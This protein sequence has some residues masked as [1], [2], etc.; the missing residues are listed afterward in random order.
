MGSGDLRKALLQL[1]YLLATGD[2]HVLPL[3]VD[4]NHRNGISLWQKI[5]Q[6]V[7][8]PAVKESKRRKKISQESHKDVDVLTEIAN[9]LENVSLISKL[10]ELEDISVH[11]RNMKSVMSLSITEDMRPYSHSNSISSNIAD[12]LTREIIHKKD[13][14][15][16]NTNKIFTS[17]LKRRKANNGIN[18]VLSTI[19]LTTDQKILSEDYLPCIRTICRAEEAR[20]SSNNKRG[21]RFFHYL[22]GT[23][24]PSN[25]SN[26]LSASCKIFQEKSE[27]VN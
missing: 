16:Q 24:L 9:N 17:L 6:C 25:S 10:I 13:D 19:A 23:K 3:V 2:S 27:Q 1:Q 11:H 4:T 12:W 14:T 21:N 15:E 26:I 5:P 7:Y 18:S 20:N 8:K 22:N